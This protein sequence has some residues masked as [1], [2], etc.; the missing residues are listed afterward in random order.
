MPKP[1][2]GAHGE[3]NWPLC[4]AAFLAAFPMAWLLGVFG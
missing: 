4:L 1:G 2:G 3:D